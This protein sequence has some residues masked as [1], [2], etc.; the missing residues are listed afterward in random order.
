MK[1]GVVFCK[2]SLLGFGGVVFVSFKGRR[3]VGSWG[4]V[5]FLREYF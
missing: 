1:F 4:F 3:V 5:I 2:R